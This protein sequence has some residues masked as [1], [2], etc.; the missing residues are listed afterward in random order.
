MFYVDCQVKK[1]G[2]PYFSGGQKLAEAWA[3]SE[4]LRMLNPDFSKF[5]HMRLP[6]DWMAKFQKLDIGISFT[7]EDV[8]ASTIS[9]IGGKLLAERPTYAKDLMVGRPAVTPIKWDAQAC[10]KQLTSPAVS[11]AKDFVCFY[12]CPG[13]IESLLFLTASFMLNIIPLPVTKKIQKIHAQSNCAADAAYYHDFLHGIAM[14]MF[15]YPANAKPIEILLTEKSYR[16]MAKD[17]IEYCTNADRSSRERAKMIW[18]TFINFHEFPFSLQ[19]DVF[20]RK[21]DKKTTR[22]FKSLLQAHL[23]SLK[24]YDDESFNAKLDDPE[25]KRLIMKELG[26][27]ESPLSCARFSWRSLLSHSAVQDSANQYASFF[28]RVCQE[29]SV[30]AQKA[31]KEMSQNLRKAFA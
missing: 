24:D 28:H 1:F 31:K 12:P 18:G 29:E 22:S 5:V 10:D 4:D 11:R 9:K 14:L 21:N 30:K 16:L 23:D 6:G 25:C 19:V 2:H 13:G 7:C 26:P 8:L 27:T 15:R 20:T 17:F 3:F